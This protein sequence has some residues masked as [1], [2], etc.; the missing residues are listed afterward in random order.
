MTREDAAA[1]VPG[2][3]AAP[4]GKIAMLRVPVTLPPEHFSALWRN[5]TAKA[6]K[7]GGVKK[8]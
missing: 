7:K 1:L 6:K 4:A 5:V 8:K 2:V 3:A